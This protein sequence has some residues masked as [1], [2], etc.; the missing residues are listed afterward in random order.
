[1]SVCRDDRIGH[2]AAGTSVLRRA[3]RVGRR[4]FA[5]DCSNA[6]WL[7]NRRVCAWPTVLR[8]RLGT[9]VR[10]NRKKTAAADW[11]CGLCCC[12]GLVRSCHVAMATLCGAHSRWHF[13]VGGTA[14]RGGLRCRYDDGPR[15][16]PGDGRAW[17]GDK[18]RLCRGSRARRNIGSQG[19]A[20]YSTIFVLQA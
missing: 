9:L 18:P 10:S 7:D 17:H 19:P 13:V 16:R 4:R 20:F 3:T 6:R 5:P 12:A 15:A 8:P 1:M 11:D 2:H 14:G